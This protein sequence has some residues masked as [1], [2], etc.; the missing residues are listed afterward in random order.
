[1]YIYI[2]IRIGFDLSDNDG[3]YLFA[4]RTLSHFFFSET[5]FLQIT[6]RDLLLIKG[7]AL[8]FVSLNTAGY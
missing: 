5:E 8:A 6:C 3:L 2:Y 7:L 4:A 1:M